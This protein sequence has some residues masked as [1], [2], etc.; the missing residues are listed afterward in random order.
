MVERFLLPPARQAESGCR[1]A[2]NAAPCDCATGA[3]D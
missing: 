3:C 2:G 1:L